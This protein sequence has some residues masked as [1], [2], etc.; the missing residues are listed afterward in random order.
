MSEDCFK[1]MEDKI[2]KL[3]EAVLAIARMEER[4]LTVF[5][6]LE[7]VDGSIKKMDDRIDEWFHTTRQAQVAMNTW[8]RQYNQIRPHHTLNMRPPA[9][10]TRLE[11]PKI[12]GRI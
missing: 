2:D 12:N 6:R 7:N 10:E 11:K 4:M 5:K 1:R 8:L 9:P 3:S